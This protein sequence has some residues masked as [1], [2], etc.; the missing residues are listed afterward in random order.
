MVTWLGTTRGNHQLGEVTYVL[1]KIC[2]ICFVINENYLSSRRWRCLLFLSGLR[3]PRL[4]RRW[5][6]LFQ[7]AVASLYDDGCILATQ[8]LLLKNDDNV[9]YASVRVTSA[10][11]VEIVSTS[12]AYC[13]DFGSLQST[14]TSLTFF[15]KAEPY[16]RRTVYPLKSV[17]RKKR[18]KCRVLLPEGTFM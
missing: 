5:I 10:K 7:I 6:F 18:R 8:S 17:K 3:S 11:S 12:K 1:S 2:T 9:N 16:L 13:A 14:R 15:S 4:W